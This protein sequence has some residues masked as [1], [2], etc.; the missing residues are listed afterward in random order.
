MNADEIR[1]LAESLPARGGL[2]RLARLLGFDDPLPTRRRPRD[3][4]AP[5]RTMRTISRGTV[6]LHIFELR[7][8]LDADAL[9][10]ELVRLVLMHPAHP[11]ERMERD[12][13][14]NAELA[15]QEARGGAV[16]PKYTN[17]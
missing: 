14:R 6:H 3:L 9:R 10:L 1:A 16:V 15:L 2:V 17:H 7:A 11:T 5:V 8:P 12:H 13:E 4:R